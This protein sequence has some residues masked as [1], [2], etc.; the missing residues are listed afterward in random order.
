MAWGV[1]WGVWKPESEPEG[2]RGRHLEENVG[3][4]SVLVGPGEG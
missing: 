1:F 3:K 4:P 2:G